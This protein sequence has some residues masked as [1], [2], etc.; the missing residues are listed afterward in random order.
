MV[1]TTGVLGTLVGLGTTGGVGPGVGPGGGKTTVGNGAGPSG[2]GVF[3]VFWSWISNDCV[4]C[5]AVAIDA[6]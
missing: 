5:N 2:T 4:W 6:S 1:G 3:V